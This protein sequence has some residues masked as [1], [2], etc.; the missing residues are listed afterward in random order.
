MSSRGQKV[1]GTAM[2]ACRF[3][4]NSFSKPIWIV[5]GLLF[6]T[7][8][9]YHWQLWQCPHLPIPSGF[10]IPSYC[11]FSITAIFISNSIWNSEHLASL[12][13]QYFLN[14]FLFSITFYWS[15]RKNGLSILFSMF[16]QFLFLWNC[17]NL[18]DVYT[19]FLFLF[20]FRYEMN[21]K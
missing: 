18:G 16:V 4:A 15:V 3:S 21:A 7:L 5:I 2:W 13:F 9:N 6:C 20:C 17:P 19:L 10:H 1:V 8:P 14:T 11:Y 12:A